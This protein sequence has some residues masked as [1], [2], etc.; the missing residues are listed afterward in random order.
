MKIKGY[1]WKFESKEDF[2]KIVNECQSIKTLIDKLGLK[3]SGSNHRT[4]KKK[5]KELQLDITHFKGQGW[6]KG[7]TVKTDIRVE[8]IGKSLK[9]GYLSGEIIP[10][11]LGKHHLEDAK[12]KMSIARI[13]RGNIHGAG[14]GRTGWYNGYWCDSSWELAWVIYNLE[15]D[16][17]FKR[18][19]EGFE[20]EYLGKIHKFYPDFILEDG[21]YVEIK[22]WLDEKNL[23][24]IRLFKGQLKVIK[25]IEMIPY[26]EYTIKKYGKDYIRLYESKMRG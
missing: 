14:R 22:G 21:S 17:K 20:Y 12:K 11:F 6:N 15:H 18:N 2:Q 10:S 1:K 7:L 25:K 9:R 4:L 5:I 23:E 13:K 3:Q 26:I 8:N 24:K 16:I 19:T